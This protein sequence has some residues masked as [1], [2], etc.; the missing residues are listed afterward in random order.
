MTRSFLARKEA[1]FERLQSTIAQLRAEVQGPQR[2][3][4]GPGA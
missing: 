3:S 1:E 4:G 2:A